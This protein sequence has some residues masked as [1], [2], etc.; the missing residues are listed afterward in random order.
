M[1]EG[2]VCLDQN[3]EYCYDI[4]PEI[5]VIGCDFLFRHFPTSVENLY[6]S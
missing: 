5:N 1:R 4:G 3:K 2:I 6:D